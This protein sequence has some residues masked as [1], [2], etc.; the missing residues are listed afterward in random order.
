MTLTLANVAENVR[1]LQPL[2]FLL[3]G[4]N[5]QWREIAKTYPNLALAER[6]AMLVKRQ[7]PEQRICVAKLVCEVRLVSQP[8][9]VVKVEDDK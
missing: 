5:N 1:A 7:L 9:E 8:F 3:T 4:D 2:Y 6:D